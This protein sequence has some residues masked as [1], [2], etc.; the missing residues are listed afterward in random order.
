MKKVALLLI[1]A[2]F[3]PSLGL[4]WLAVRSL[5]DQQ[6]V[7]ERQQYLLLQGVADQLAQ[8]VNED[9]TERQAEF[10][11]QVES[12]RADRD[13]LQMA[14][15]F[16]AELKTRWPLAEVGFAV[17]LE[18]QI[19]NPSPLDGEAPREFYL[20][21]SAFLGN[22]ESVEVYWNT[23]KGT[24]SLS[25]APRQDPAPPAFSKQNALKRAV[26]PQQAAGGGGE[27]DSSS[28]VLVSEAE[29]RQ[30]VGDSSDGTLARFVDNRLR[31]MFWHRSPAVPS[32][33]FGAQVSLTGLVAG[34]APRLRLSPELSADAA[35]ALLDDGARPLVVAPE[36]FRPPSWKRPFA[37]TEIGESLPHWEI[38]VYL[39]DPEQAGRTA[40]TLTLTLLLLVGVLVSVIGTGGWLVVT[41]LRRQ[42]K[43]ARQKSDFVSNVSHELKTP[44]TS[45]RMFAEL[46]GED[47]VTDPARRRE[48][49]GIIGTE[50]ARLTRLINQVLDFARI[51]RGERT[52]SFAPVDLR[53]VV[54]EAVETCRPPLE[55]AGVVLR[56]PPMAE[57]IRVSGDRDALVQVAVNLLSNVEKYAARGGEVVIELGDGAPGPGVHLRVLDRGP[58]VPAGWEERIFEQFVRADDSLTSGIPGSGLGLTLARQMA[59]AHGGDIHCTRRAGGG[60]CFTLTLP[61]QTSR[62]TP[63]SQDP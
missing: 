9:L 51:E 39:R 13:S 8:G 56:L 41:D 33:V 25:A 36:G 3:V 26:V 14:R 22:R 58:G 6:I 31:L 16:D 4:A 49:L 50:S 57:P 7:L 37:A 35:V 28:R 21:N 60:T 19:L 59:R 46:L 54:R 55:A 11:A 1:L 23:P 63:G 61:R 20:A 5:R 48:F 10:A 32:L 2:V 30:L 42:L 47:R 17:T 52:W 27:G 62:E 24:V 45:I 53:D 44:L 40:R 12:L 15:Q 18:G 34:L 29:F 38:A 43:L